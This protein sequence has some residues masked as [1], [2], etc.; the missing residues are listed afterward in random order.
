MNRSR[1][2]RTF[3][4]LVLSA[5]LALGLA[6][7]GEDEPATAVQPP[8]PA[9]QPPAFQ[10]ETA[11]VRLGES[12]QTVTLMTARGAAGRGTGRRSRAG[13]RSRCGAR[14]GIPSGTS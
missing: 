1:I 13:P 3:G 8:A 5:A 2:D 9:P 11:E 4:L 6:G 12:G 7:C 10:P 14:G